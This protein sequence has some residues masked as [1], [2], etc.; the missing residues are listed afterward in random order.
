VA[1][2]ESAADPRFGGDRPK[3][4]D[5]LAPVGREAGADRATSRHDI[6]LGSG[7]SMLS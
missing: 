5:R 7:L 6:Q 3:I 4:D 2:T 1:L